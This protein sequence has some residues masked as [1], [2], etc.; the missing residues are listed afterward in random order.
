VTCDEVRERLPEHVLGTIEGPQD[1]QIREHLRGCAGCRQELAALDDGLTQFARAAHDVSPPT[2]LQDRVRTVLQD[3]WRE[4]PPQHRRAPRLRW[5]AVAAAVLMVAA[6]LSWGLA[7]SRRADNATLGATSYQR[8][9]DVLGGKDFR[10]GQLQA[11]A[12]QTLEGSV[13]IYDS[14]VDQSWAVV[15]VRAPGI[16]GAASATLHAPDGRTI[17]MW[18]LAIDHEGDGAAWL[19]TSVNL[20]GF[21]RITVTGPDGRPLATASVSAT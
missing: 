16:E 3:E 12:G 10:V 20:E 9:L 15:F 7:Q 11:A 13:I 14:H 4:R 17:D 6:S 21:N 5:L 2:E 1:L 18:D 8:L 19:V